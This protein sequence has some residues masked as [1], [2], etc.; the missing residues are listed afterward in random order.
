M[1]LK[2]FTLIG[3]ALV[4]VSLVGC[5]GGS[6]GGTAGSGGST[7]AR[8]G[9][10][11]VYPIPNNP[12]SL[13]P[14]VVQDGDTI[15]ILQQ[16]Y[17]G[18]VTWSTDNK[19]VPLLAEKW[20]VQEGGKVY[21]FHLKKGVKFHNGKEVTA[22][23]FK[24]SWDRNC[25]PELKSQTAGA[26]MSDIVGVNEVVEGKAKE[27]SGVKV[28]DPYTLRVEIDKPRPYFLGKMTYLTFAVMPKDSTPATEV[29]DIKNMIGTGA[30]VP[31]TFEPQ[32]IFSLKRFDDYHAGKPAIDGIDRPVVKDAPARLSRY[33]GGEFDLCLLQREDID[34]VN[35]DT[36]VK[37]HLK[38]WDR[39][40]I[41]YIGLN[42]G[43]AYAPFKD[44]RVRQAIAMA[45]DRDR[46]VNDFLG[47]VNKK[48]D[49]IVPPGVIGHRAKAAVYDYDVAGA[50][51]L[52]AEAGYPDGKGLPPVDI[53]FRQGYRDI[54]KV[55]EAV[56][57]QLQTNL[58]MNVKLRETEWR[59]YL[60]RYNKGEN[61]FFHMR[62]A[63]DYLDP[64]NFL[65][66]MLATDGPENHIF[67]SNPE[68]DKLCAEA[69][70]LMDEAKRLE[71]YAKAEDIVLQ[72]A[73]WIPI[74]FQRDA[75]LMH[76]RVKGLRESLFG[77]LPHT[78]VSLEG[79]AVPAETGKEEG[80]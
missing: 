50:K 42:N 74:Y 19:P 80:K 20:D 76:P 39:P 52:L 79:E 62:W 11:L 26:Y 13:D 1:M 30:F 18:L 17:E 22:E 9:N 72:D 58:G 53:F 45:I 35:K 32:Q 70:S 21:V 68:F 63:A 67:Y 75:E 33:R 14:G 31:E 2:H 51:K 15:D 60:E 16:V 61:P 65:S 56:A 57:A 43:E 49:S 66:H 24:W 6:G 46:I 8:K 38:F 28:I 48:A 34:A 25:R 12:T 78:T 44:K 23:D 36:K 54:S 3:A 69:D 71:L 40:S 27:I 55:A 59:A 41:F 5:G 4:V 29:G 64:Q 77:H 7:L 47:G 73:P 37:D 10:R